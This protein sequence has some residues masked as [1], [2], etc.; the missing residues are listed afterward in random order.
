MT[1]CRRRRTK[2]R[3]EVMA[4]ARSYSAPGQCEKRVGLRHVLL[5]DT[6]VTVC[7]HH[8]AML[9]RGVRPAGAR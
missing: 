4:A 6:T 3:C 2:R 1:P 7:G 9:G 5:G 8:A